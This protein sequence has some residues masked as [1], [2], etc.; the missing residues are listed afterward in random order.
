MD[1]RFRGKGIWVAA[2]GL[3]IIFL[4]LMLCGLGAM[5]TMFL[6]QGP[7]YAVVPQ[8]QPPVAEEGA[9]QPPVYY[10]PVAGRHVGVGPFGFIG[11]AI[12]ML[13]KLLF[14]GVL[15]LLLF[16]LVRRLFWG[17]RYWHHRHPGKPPRGKPY[18]GWGPWAWH[19][20]GEAAEDEG[21][22]DEPEPA[23]GG[24]E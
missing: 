11:A 20:Y 14:F 15:V 2:G 17:P 7:E 10:G 1:E 16:G 3:A 24:T 4:C 13:F 18:P 19:C 23:Y 12:G 22:P 5:G 21:E 6:R 9:V 8:G